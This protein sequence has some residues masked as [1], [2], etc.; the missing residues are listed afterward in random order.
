MKPKRSSRH[1]G[2]EGPLGSQTAQTGGQS[3]A[4]RL[5]RQTINAWRGRM[6]EG[7]LD[8]K[9]V[10][11]PRQSTSWDSGETQSLTANTRV[12]KI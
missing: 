11:E 4:K 1:G 2:M 6:V 7:W 8:R 5:E 9:R 12:Y 3:N 10:E